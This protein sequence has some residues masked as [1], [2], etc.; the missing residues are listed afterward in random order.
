[1]QEKRT[2]AQ[3]RD[4]TRAALIAAARDLFLEQGYAATGTPDVVARAGVT[5]GAL[6]HH[7]ADKQA[8]FHAVV[9]D[10]AAQIAAAIRA[11]SPGG[12]DAVTALLDGASAYFAA[13]RIPGR[14]RL[15]LLEG[16][17]VLGPQAMRG[18]DAETGGGTLREGIGDALGLAVSTEAVAAIADLVSAMFDRAVLAVSNGADERIYQ[19]AIARLLM[20][21]VR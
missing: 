3:R 14:T 1:M 11:G 12:S 18:I 15:M 10:E 4:E 21:L 6:Y 19:D 16:P 9:A 13:M 2:N 8:L 17:A 5:R 7:F 20:L